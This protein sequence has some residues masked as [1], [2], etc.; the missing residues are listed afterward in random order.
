[1]AAA[2]R[3]SPEL[4]NKINI[5]PVVNRFHE[6]TAEDYIETGDILNDH[7]AKLDALTGTTSGKP[8]FGSY[9][10]L[11]LLQAA[12][13]VGTENAY[14]IIDAGI[15]ATPQL[16]L[17]DNTDMIW[18]I[19]SVAENVKFVTNFAALPAPGLE[20]MI[21]VTLDNFK[22]YVW[23]NS[24]YNLIFSLKSTSDLINDVPFL[25][26]SDALSTVS[27]TNKL[28]TEADLNS[29]PQPNELIEK[30]FH[31]IE[32]FDWHVFAQKYRWNGVLYEA[33]EDLVIDIITIDPAPTTVDFKRFDVI[34]FNDDFTF[35]KVKG[36]EGLNP[37]IPKIDIRTQ[38]QL[39]VILVEYGTTEPSYLTKQLM[40][41]EGIGLPAEF[42]VTK[43]G[44]NV[45]IN[46]TTQFSS[47]TKC[48]KVVNP[49]ASNVLFLD[50]NATFNSLDIDTISFKIKNGQQS[51]ASFYLYSYNS[52]G[53][54]Y[55]GTTEIKNGKYGYDS[56][57]ITDW[58]IIIVPRSK[59]LG[60]SEI[61]NTG[62]ALTFKPTTGTYYFDEF[63]MNGNFTQ[64]PVVSGHT[65]DNLTILDQITQA[66]INAWNS[67][68]SWVTT[69]GANVLFKADAL[70]AVTPTNKIITQADVT[71]FGGGDMLATNN[72]SEVNPATARTNLGLATAK[73]KTDFLIITQ[74]VD[75]DDIEIRVNNLDAA[76]VLKGGWDA[77][78]GT[79]PGAGIAQAGFSYQVMVA[80]TVNG[81]DFSINDRI[82]AL[83]DNAS[84]AVYATNWLKADYSDLV[85]SF[86]GR[87]GAI[88][89][90][91]TDISDLM[92]ASTA[93]TTLVDT[94][95]FSLFDTVLKKVTWANI[96]AT[97]K[98]Y[99]D[100]VYAKVYGT[101]ITN[102]TTTGTYTLN[103]ALGNDWKLTLTGVTT[104]AESNLPTGTDTI[105]FTMK[106][107]GNFGLT[108]PAY[109]TVI[110]DTYDGTIW[111]F[112]AVQIHKGDATQEAT[113][114]IS[115]F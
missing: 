36:D 27:S 34:V 110:G 96:K 62:W 99:F 112:F 80:G 26:A 87:T 105:E 100:T 1:M 60:G 38:I 88:V 52:I 84:T 63:A 8:N 48:I 5:N 107:T 25:Y 2:K 46:D 58:Q 4:T 111:N 30:G 19:N 90:L 9:T 68:S 89:L 66:L 7:A 22:A 85:A 39:T 98:T 32:N 82:I 69:N 65:H 67:A 74:T 49:V 11:A 35:S 94:D 45:T 55:Q 18:T 3:P 78:A 50:K 29:S 75:L 102:A 40:Y 71:S 24:Q 13:P 15:G 77:S 10:S 43:V 6:A 95:I 33:P 12:Y 72:L 57:N 59:I 21:Y 42:A 61:H 114:F 76:V 103:H 51:N 53:A 28:I 79:F 113:C 17:W 23:K 54:F 20:N 64:A 31:H 109:W 108:V 16:A 115:N 97:L 41:D 44:A 86:N 91:N 93:K 47:G 106:V 14:A 70:T 83:V 73:T 101:R 92:T 81:I 56:Q 37:A 104:I